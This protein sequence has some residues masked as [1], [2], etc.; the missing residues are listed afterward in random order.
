MGA[1]DDVAWM[2]LQNLTCEVDASIGSR[3]R[4]DPLTADWRWIARNLSAPSARA[5]ER[6]RTR[7]KSIEGGQAM[8]GETRTLI[9]MACVLQPLLT[10]VGG[11]SVDENLDGGR[12]CVLSKPKGWRLGR[13]LDKG[14]I[15]WKMNTLLRRSLR[16]DRPERC[17]QAGPTGRRPMVDRG[18]GTAGKAAIIGDSR[19]STVFGERR[20]RW[21]LVQ[22]RT[23]NG[24]S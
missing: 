6:S 21:T 17:R 1:H 4:N 2:T 18:R 24:G 12:R 20:C 14:R 16:S 22:W 23:R 9:A 5:T 8:T 11:T 7:P 10:G 3:R 15:H 19:R 13:Q